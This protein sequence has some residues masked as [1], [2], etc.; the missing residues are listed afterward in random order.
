MC[1]SSRQCYS[2]LISLFNILVIQRDMAISSEYYRYKY[3]AFACSYVMSNVTI[4]HYTTLIVD[5]IRFCLNSATMTRFTSPL[6][7]SSYQHPERDGEFGALQQKTIQQMMERG[8]EY[9]TLAEHP[10]SWAEDQDPFGHVMAQAYAHISAKCFTRF[11]ES[12]H[13]KLQDEFPKFMS[14]RGIGPMTNRYTMTIKTP[15]KYPDLVCPPSRDDVMK[16]G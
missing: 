15:I 1:I 14:G 10:V 2:Q 13:E 7:A 4:S 12:F 11:L 16:R 6:I 5:I 9:S 8:I 3:W